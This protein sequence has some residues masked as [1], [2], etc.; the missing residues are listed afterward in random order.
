M[1]LIRALFLLTALSACG[2]DLKTPVRYAVRPVVQA[3]LPPI[4]ADQ[5]EA[6]AMWEQLLQ[7]H[8]TAEAMA[9]EVR[10]SGQ[11]G[12]VIQLEGRFDRAGNGRMTFS[13]RSEGEWEDWPE[14]TVYARDSVFTWSR[15]KGQDWYDSK[16]E[17]GW[18][19]FDLKGLGF[20][21]R[22]LDISFLAP[23]AGEEAPEP[24]AV[25]FLAGRAD[26]PRW[27]GLRLDYRES[28]PDG[29][30]LS[31][32][33]SIWL[34]ED[35][36]PMESEVVRAPPSVRG[37]KVQITFHQHRLGDA[38]EVLRPEDRLPEEVQAP[39]PS[40]P[41]WGYART[42]GRGP[43]VEESAASRRLKRLLESIRS[44]VRI[45]LVASTAST[46]DFGAMTGAYSCLLHDS[47]KSLWEWD[48]RGWFVH[49]VEEAT[50]TDDWYP[51]VHG[52]GRSTLW[53]TL[54]PDGKRV[55][56]SHDLRGQEA[57]LSQID[58]LPMRAWM[59]SGP[60]TDLERVTRLSNWANGIEVYQV[61]WW[62][63]DSWDPEEPSWTETLV[64][65]PSGELKEL[66]GVASQGIVLKVSLRIQ[67]LDLFESIP[68]PF[69]PPRPLRCFG[70]L[71]GFWP[72]IYM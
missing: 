46:D 21:A 5:E 1:T 47:G 54:S 44:A 36:V 67:S 2:S 24:S 56:G 17:D 12:F 27:I 35:G 53:W 28:L 8:A 3:S 18:V 48:R 9:I 62:E 25:T 42:G 41:R 65:S 58:L 13:S 10:C 30:V 55:S 52:D 4:P 34:D 16:D 45:R 19:P 23:F 7:R 59:A 32:H 40:L 68:C 37:A 11:A 49:F 15:V 50:D 51:R 69:P 64:F 6:R 43:A 66:R 26:H 60:I 14:T 57:L 61:E 72:Q 22:D 20:L 70:G 38:A 71:R 29:I 39:P 31:C 33:E 63:E